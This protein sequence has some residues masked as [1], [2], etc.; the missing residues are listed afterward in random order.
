MSSETSPKSSSHSFNPFFYIRK[1]YHWTLRWAE[2]RHGTKAL[3]VIAFVESSFFPIPP[4]VLLMAMG[5]SKPKRSFVYATIC[6]VFSVLGGLFG[7]VMGAF[8]WHLL[9]PIFIGNVFSQANFNKVGELYQG[10]AFEAIFLAAFTPIP[11]KVFT[12]GAGVFAIS[13]LTLLGASI[14]G[15]SLRFFMVAAVLYTMG[16][17]VKKIVEKYFEVFTVLFAILLVGGFLLMKQ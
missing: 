11:F 7:W 6:S 2:H 8:L 5:A 9:E 13:P 10:N 3:A 15:R 17:S 12:V 1:L 16:P 4:D 14:I